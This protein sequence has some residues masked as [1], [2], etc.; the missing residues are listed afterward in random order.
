MFTVYKAILSHLYNDQLNNLILK[1][2]A[3][4]WPPFN[5]PTKCHVYK[6]TYS[7]VCITTAVYAICYNPVVIYGFVHACMAYFC[8]NMHISTKIL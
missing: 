2:T 1:L 8:V 7:S 3:H 4:C 5:F 6:A